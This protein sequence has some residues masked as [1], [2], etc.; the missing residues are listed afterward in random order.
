MK[1]ASTCPWNGSVK[2]ARN[3]YFLGWPVRVSSVVFGLVDH[4]VIS[5]V[6]LAS[7]ISAAGMAPRLALGPTIAST[8]SWVMS[9]LAAAAD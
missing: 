1:R 8:S 2:Q 3:T 6:W 7:A 4:G 9:L 5:S